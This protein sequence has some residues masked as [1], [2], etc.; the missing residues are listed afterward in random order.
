M[1]LRDTSQNDICQSII[2]RLTAGTTIPAPLFRVYDGV[3]VIAECAIG[4][5]STPVNGYSSATVADDT[6]VTGTPETYEIIGRANTVI[7]SGPIAE[8]PYSLN[9]GT[10]HV[11]GGLRLASPAMQI[12]DDEMAFVTEGATFEPIIEV[13]GTPTILWTFADGT[14]SNSATPT[15]VN[16]GSTGNRVTKLKV[17]PWSAVQTINLGYN[18][19]D[20][21]T[22]YTPESYYHDDQ[23]V[24]EIINLY[25]VKS[26][27]VRIL[28]CGDIGVKAPMQH[29]DLSDFTALEV[30]EFYYNDIKGY[31]VAGCTALKRLCFEG[32]GIPVCD[33]YDCV[34]LEDFRGAIGTY[35]S[36]HA[37]Y[38]PNLWHL[39]VQGNS[40][41]SS[42]PA[43]GE[44][45]PA[46]E[47]LWAFNC[48]LSGSVGISTANTQLN[49]VRLNDND[50]SSA[51]IDAI[52]AQM[53]S[54]NKWITLIY[55]NGNSSPTN[56]ENVAALDAVSYIFAYDA[57]S[58]PSS[59]I[60][61]SISS[62]PSSSESSS[63]SSSF[64]GSFSNSASPSTSPS[65][66]PSASISA[67]LS[68]S[69]SA[70]LSASSSSSP[71]ASG[72][73]ITTIYFTTDGD[74]V[75]MEVQLSGACDVTWH[76]SD[77]TTSTSL[78][79]TKSFGSAATRNHYVTFSNPSAVTRFG[80]GATVCMIYSVTA[81][82][83]EFPNCAYLFFYRCGVVDMSLAGGVFNQVHLRNDE[84]V[85]VRTPQAQ[86]DEW[87]ID[88]ADSSWADA[89]RDLYMQDGRS[90]AS[91][92]AWAVLR[93]AGWSISGDY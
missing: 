11:I 32:C 74:S 25:L 64:S 45:F 60:S 26:S 91:D 29:I 82:W 65:S 71:S 41:L 19:G 87:L 70:S 75:N 37:S 7:M 33:F 81:D 84:G 5:F 79:P 13:T 50:F 77:D 86:L 6:G 83:S 20:D 51:D 17:T 89:P 18:G 9:A 27:L 21:G 22:G 68:S 14:T 53:L 92:A 58:S 1:I 52:I 31:S 39:C 88:L 54:I 62:S 93:A 24:S 35:S 85:N 61:S 56:A 38:H 57:L 3:S 40:N 43:I 72:E 30:A 55:I 69:P 47:D 49:S 42:L 12:C 16:Y 67:S 28:A 59:S 2:T 78:T 10:F 44:T 73:D 15:A 46:I 66:S 63:M 90:N 8:V 48:S 36:I 80:R 34:A 23:R 4:T 76:W